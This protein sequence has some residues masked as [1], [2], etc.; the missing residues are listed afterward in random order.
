MYPNTNDFQMKQSAQQSAGL[1]G[2]S[3]HDAIGQMPQRDKSPVEVSMSSLFE[4]IGRLQAEVDQLIDRLAP[5]SFMESTGS[6][7]CSDGT[8]SACP[9]VGMLDQASERIEFTMT[10]IADARARLC[11]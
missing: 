2:A 4:R 11:I 6:N 3:H 5:V 1:I 7:A 8:K 9:M 10:R